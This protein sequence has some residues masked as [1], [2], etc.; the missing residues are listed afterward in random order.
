MGNV[1]KIAHRSLTNA[2]SLERGRRERNRHRNAGIEKET[3][4][5][6]NFREHPV[7]IIIALAGPDLANNSSHVTMAVNL[8]HE[9]AAGVAIADVYAI[10]SAR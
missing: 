2:D 7:E 6:P 9:R 4:V 3:C 8:D 1:L 5:I 10:A